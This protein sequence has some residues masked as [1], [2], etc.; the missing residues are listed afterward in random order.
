MLAVVLSIALVLGGLSAAS[1]QSTTY[2]SGTVI[3]KGVPLGGADV[4]LSGNNLDVHRTTDA[5]GQFSFLGLTVGEYT[6]TAKKGDL[7]V[8]RSIELT[9]SG[10]TLS[11]EVTQLQEIGHVVVAN[12]P[13]VAGSSGSDVVI[14]SQT[15]TKLPDTNSLPNVLVQAPAAARGS[16]GQIHLNGDHNGLSYIIDGVPLPEELNRVLGNEVDPSTISFMNLIEGAYPAQYGSH[17]GGVLDIGTKSYTGP[18]GAN[19]DVTGGSYNYYNGI[20]DFH[21]PV[22]NGGS[23]VLSGRFSHDGRAL[24]P[25]DQTM[26]HDAGSDVSQF[27]R[28]SLPT[29]KSNFV[30]V[31]LIH[32]LQTF[33]IPPDLS[34]GVPAQT[35]DNEYQEDTFLAV[36]F[37][38]QISENSSIS[39]GPSFKT[40][41][42]LDTNDLAND[43]AGAAGMPL[44]GPPAPPTA[45]CTDFSDCPF[46]SVL[47]DRTSQVMQ[48]NADYDSHSERHDFRAGTLLAL[49]TVPKD[50]VIT[51]QPGNQLNPSGA[52]FTVTDTTTNNG[53]SQAF[54]AQDGWHFLRH[55]LVDYGVRYDQF[56]AGSTGFAGEWN[57]TSP[58]AKLTYEFSPRASAYIYYGRLFEPFSLESIS[59]QAAAALY[60]PSN[61]SS[62]VSFDLKPERDSLYE[63][64]FHVPLGIADVG[65][66]ISQRNATD[67][68]DDTQVGA[69]N[70][71]QDINFPQG[72]VSSQS[73]YTNVPLANESRAYLSVSHVIAVNSYNCET[74]L[75]QNCALAGPPGGD[76]V[77]A[78]HDQHWD[79]TGGV[80]VNDRHGGWFS[81]DGEYGSGLSLG[82]PA[83][84]NPCAVVDCINYK[85]AP[86]LVFNIAKALPI[87][88]G[89]IVFSIQNVFNDMYA[90]TLDNSLQGTHYARPRSFDI[91]Y[92]IGQR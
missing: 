32:A 54:Y 7:T 46:F 6:L 56:T 29:G 17:F 66:R 11:L 89:Q 24:D 60:V 31:D 22:G 65:F 12:R 27:L 41:R 73:L 86:H 10:T 85:T 16:N 8:S 80:I 58:R 19:L 53:T 47:A 52:P 48:F 37:R 61:L 64:G 14:D 28:L 4:E 78:D 13:P 71:H 26:L 49:Q 90:I 21:A 9:S 45:T 79:S 87:A 2:I 69:T 72:R 63:A 20:V 51:I 50:Y 39:F 44:L 1:A 38:H 74:Q 5:R 91:R 35:D 36:Q 81:L 23:F 70:L 88:S 76:F 18:A 33:Q 83:V 42:V 68:I 84:P 34:Q 62:G 67:W 25:P 92:I 82:F 77:Q 59:P 55:W 40:S 3:S 43:L 75:L 15:L 57:Q 30:N